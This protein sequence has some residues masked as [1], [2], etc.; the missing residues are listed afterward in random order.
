LLCQLYHLLIASVAP[1][2]TSESCLLHLRRF[3][4]TPFVDGDHWV[5]LLM[6]RGLFFFTG[7][8][9]FCMAPCQEQLGRFGQVLDQ[10][11]LI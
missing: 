1:S 2:A 7:S 11:K 9:Q 3:Y 8:H 4:R 10:V 5:V 6:L